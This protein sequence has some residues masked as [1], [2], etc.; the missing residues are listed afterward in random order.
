MVIYSLIDILTILNEYEATGIV[1]NFF[2]YF[3]TL[4]VATKKLNNY[5]S[6]IYSHKLL[7]TYQAQ[8]AN[9]LKNI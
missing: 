3:S 8:W 5:L 9:N 6:F 7:T 2:K 4:T 1:D